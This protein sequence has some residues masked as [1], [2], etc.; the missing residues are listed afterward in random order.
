MN[1]T[2]S[3]GSS[4]INLNFVWGTDLNEAMDDIRTRVD[5]VRG[6]LPED[7]ENVPARGSSSRPDR[8]DDA[9]DRREDRAD[10]LEYGERVFNP[11]DGLPRRRRGRDCASL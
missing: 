11:R 3:E 6:R 8:A 4:Q 10:L 2:S 7:A 9:D 5:R 1:S